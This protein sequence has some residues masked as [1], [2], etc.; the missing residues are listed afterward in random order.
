MIIYNG[1]SI[2]GNTY[3]SQVVQP[4]IERDNRKR[5]YIIKL[6]GKLNNIFDTN[7]FVDLLN[8]IK[9]EDRLIYLDSTILS[10]AIYTFIEVIEPDLIRKGIYKLTRKKFKECIDLLEAKKIIIDPGLKVTLVRY[11]RYLIKIYEKR[12]SKDQKE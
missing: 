12:K 2:R 7:K 10:Y 4:E 11:L 9:D 8:I 3:E 1:N 6:R 5:A